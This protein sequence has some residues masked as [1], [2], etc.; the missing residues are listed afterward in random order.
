VVLALSGFAEGKMSLTDKQWA[1]LEPL[2]EACLLHAK[3]PSQ[4][5]R[6]TIGATLWRHENGANGGPP[7]YGPW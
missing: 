4:H 5:L 1:M 2:V 3:V 6:R 7:E